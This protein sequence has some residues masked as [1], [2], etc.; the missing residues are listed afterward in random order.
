M[1]DLNPAQPSETWEEAGYAFNPTRHSL[2]NHKEWKRSSQ[3]VPD[4]DGRVIQLILGPKGPPVPGQSSFAV[5]RW[6]LGYVRN[7]SS[8]DG[9]PTA[10]IHFDLRLHEVALVPDW[11]PTAIA[12]DTNVSP[13]VL[14]VVS[15]LAYPCD[16]KTLTGFLDH[17]VYGHD[18]LIKSGYVTNTMKDME[19]GVLS[20][21]PHNAGGMGAYDGFQHHFQIFDLNRLYM[22]P[23]AEQLYISS[24]YRSLS[25]MGPQTQFILGSIRSQKLFTTLCYGSDHVPQTSIYVNPRCLGSLQTLRTTYQSHARSVG[26]D[27]RFGGYT[28]LAKRHMKLNMSGRS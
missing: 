25:A 24:L 11:L 4:G 9:D 20:T 14:G 3:S 8:G 28:G 27:R 2:G 18:R 19:L 5:F 21:V 23:M 16:P 12:A 22:N 13:S 17:E 26:H 1:G 10:R 7:S 6:I 15:P